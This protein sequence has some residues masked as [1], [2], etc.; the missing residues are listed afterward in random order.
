MKIKTVATG[1]ASLTLLLSSAVFA[2]GAPDNHG[3]DQ[4]GNQG[5]AHGNAG[6]PGHDQGGQNRAP[7]Q[8]QGGPGPMA[9]HDGH[10]P[11]PHSDWHK[12]G[13][14]PADYRGGQY[15]VDDWHAHQLRQPP[16]GYHWVNVNG[17]YVL[18]AMASGLIAQIISGH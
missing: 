1:L 4:G 13:R 11:Q 3:G 14:V 5:G 18:V 12:G 8:A 6:G 2:Q 10:G 7:T 16:R 15:V 9:Q 17:D